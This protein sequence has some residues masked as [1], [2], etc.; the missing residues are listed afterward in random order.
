MPPEKKDIFTPTKHLTGI[1]VSPW[2][3]HAQD[4]VKQLFVADNFLLQTD[5]LPTISYL[6]PT[7]L[8]TSLHKNARPASEYILLHI[9][10]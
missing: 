6:L 7:K 4:L 2:D 9:Q 1:V 8:Q 10:F 3:L 5:Y